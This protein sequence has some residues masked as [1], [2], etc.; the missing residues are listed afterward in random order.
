MVLRGICGPKRD[1]RT[2]D[3]RKLH[4]EEPHNFY[5]ATYNYEVKEGEIRHAWEGS[6]MHTGFWWEN[7]KERDH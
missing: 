2:G 6:I 7:Q 1:E 5:T 3:R 4:K